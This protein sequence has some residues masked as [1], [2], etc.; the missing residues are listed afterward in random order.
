MPVTAICLGAVGAGKT[1]LLTQLTKQNTDTIEDDE[2]EER[3]PLPT[4]GINHFDVKESA[5]QSE[6]SSNCFSLFC[7][8]RRQ[9]DNY[10]LNKLT[11]REF[12]GALQAAWLT[13]LKG[14]LNQDLKG[15]IYVIDS[16]ASAR[17]SEAGVHLIDVIES[18]ER[19]RVPV[20]ILI[21]FTK[22]D[23][24]EDSCK[25]RIITEAR[26]LLRINHLEKW[27]K[28][29]VFDIIEY[30]AINESGLSNILNWCQNLYT[31]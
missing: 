22:I 8:R 12:G 19:N 28:Y 30:S 10:N 31:Q 25:D 20:R 17:F 13:Y 5:A 3:E 18:L 14:T 16:S 11:I 9:E 26:T 29:C 21:V 15:L 6:N 27:S 1:R 24:V 2:E 4:V 23:L 7:R